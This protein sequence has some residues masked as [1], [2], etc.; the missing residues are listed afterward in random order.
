MNPLWK[1]ASW[2]CSALLLTCLVGCHSPKPSP[3]PGSSFRAVEVDQTTQTA[4]PAQTTVPSV[5]AP[6]ALSSEYRFEFHSVHMAVPFRLVFYAADAT[7][8]NEAAR[9]AFDR[10]EVLNGLLS[11]YDP[12]SELSLL[13]RKSDDPANLEVSFPL[14]SEL[15]TVL[16]RGEAVSRASHGAFDPTVGPAVQLWRR[17]RRQRALP[18][19][20]RIQTAL[21]SVG[22]ES[23]RLVPAESNKWTAQWL[24]TGMRLD[25]GGIAK[26]YALDEAAAVLRDHGITRYLVAGAG[27]LLAGDPPPDQPGWRIE[28]GAIDHSDAP[29]PRHYWLKHA[30]LCSSG[31]V[32]QYVEIDGVRYSH[33]VNPRTGLGMTDQRQVTVIAT[34]GLL[35]DALATALS[36]AP[37]NQCLAL[38]AE[39]EAEL[40]LMR[41][42]GSGLEI[43]ESP[44]LGSGI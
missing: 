12:E 38:A 21:E 34:H 5:S 14:S 24:R 8:A 22:W 15:A 19:P 35:A 17:A 37:L 10:I 20:E 33:I 7:R 13:S 25:L 11:D 2:G 23:L 39:F 28:M 1:L 6:V 31:D 4:S 41:D 26:G 27:D 3:T 30:A 42:V 18:T 29:A 44:G 16:V 40:L 43:L 9:A 36:V 32:F